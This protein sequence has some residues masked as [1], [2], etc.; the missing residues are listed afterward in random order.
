MDPYLE[1]CWG[2]VRSSLIFLA[3]Q[4][5]QRQLGGDLVARSEDRL[6]VD[7]DEALRRQISVPDVRV[8]EHGIRDIPLRASADGIA[9]AEPTVILIEADEIAESFLQIL[10]TSVCGRVITVIEFVSPSNKLFK[11]ARKSYQDKQEQC[12]DSHT[13]LVEVDLT[14]AGRW[15]LLVEMDE[16][17][18][19]KRGEYL[20]SAYRSYTGKHGRRE[21]HGLKLRERLPAIRIPLRAGDPDIALDLQPLLDQAYDAGAYGRTLD[22]SRPLDAPLPDDDAAWAERLIAAR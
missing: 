18:A 22:Y 11:A 15:K 1:R 19:E 3:K 21:G 12:L 14:R 2:D 16:L 8:G 7:D 20:V 10:D 5:I 17:P 13:N 6:Y 4:A 9:L